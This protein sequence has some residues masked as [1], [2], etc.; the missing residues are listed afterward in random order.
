MTY[1]VKPNFRA[2]GPRL[3]KSVKDVAAAL[4]RCD[5]HQVVQ[6]LES[7]GRTSV[8]VNGKAVELSPEELD[9]R[10][11][12]RTG[13][14]LAREGAYGVALDVDLSDELIH[15]GIAREVIRGVQELRKNAGLSVEDRID[16]WLQS[17]AEMIVEALKAHEKLIASEVLAV[18]LSPSAAPDGTESEGLELDQGAVVASLRRARA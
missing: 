15:E 8:D 13:F 17:D 6:E 16:L 12:G 14:S 11:E 1:S 7:Q 18:S 2:L 10:I 9:V 5:A 4:A 3:G